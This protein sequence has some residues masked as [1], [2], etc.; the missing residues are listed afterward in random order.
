MQLLLYRLLRSL[1]TSPN[2]FDYYCIA[3]LAGVRI[4]GPTERYGA[5]IGGGE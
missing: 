3:E 2:F 5:D 4:V 1:G